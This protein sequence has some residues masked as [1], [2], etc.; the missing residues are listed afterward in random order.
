M[1]DMLNTTAKQP[2]SLHCKDTIKSG[3]VGVSWKHVLS[4]GLDLA[5][6]TNKRDFFSYGLK[7]TTIMWLD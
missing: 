7:G 4:M 3:G 6:Q 1:C 5:S 2:S